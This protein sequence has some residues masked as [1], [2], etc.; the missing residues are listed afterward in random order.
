[1]SVCWKP[2]WCECENC[3]PLVE[4][5]PDDT[6]HADHTDPYCVSHCAPGI[7]HSQCGCSRSHAANG[8]VA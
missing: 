4:V 1:M 5:T 2:E 6:G 3:G 7:K 8:G